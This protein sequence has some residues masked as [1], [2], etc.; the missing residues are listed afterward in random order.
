MAKAVLDK[1]S[2]NDLKA[3]L[4]RRER[5]LQK[6]YAEREKIDQKIAQLGGDAR[7]AGRPATAV[8]G[9]G[10]APGRRRRPRN[11]ASLAEVL[12]KVFPKGRP[13]KVA[14]AVE[15]AK[16]AGYKTKA[17]NFSTIVN[18]TLIKDPRFTQVS[19]GYY[20]VD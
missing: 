4:E 14:D 10:A 3:E 5:K 11:K 8:A 19:R 18:Q 9:A 16:R 17:K 15:G 1:L 12:L 7:R 13:M 20:Q 6:L 2:L